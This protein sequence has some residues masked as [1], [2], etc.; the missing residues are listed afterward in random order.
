MKR[1]IEELIEDT[2]TK[3]TEENIKGISE[4]IVDDLL[5]D[6]MQNYFDILSKYIKTKKEKDLSTP[7]VAR[8]SELPELTVKRVENIQSI[9][10][11][12]NL[13]KMLNS[14]GLKLAVVPIEEKNA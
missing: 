5:S 1:T 13:I 4:V 8:K 14:V 9:P 10:K 12:T 2:S 11:V 7:F 3:I 6:F